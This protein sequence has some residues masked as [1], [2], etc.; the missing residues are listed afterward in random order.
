MNRELKQLIDKTF[1]DEKLIR[2]TMS[3]PRKKS[4]TCRKISMRPV[5]L[6]GGLAYQ[7]E[8]HFEKKVTHENM[9][10]AEAAD[11]IEGHLRLEF[12]QMNIMTTD[13]DI[14]VLANKIDKPR[15]TCS[16]ACHEMP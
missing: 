11:S 5:M 8:Y 14:Q 1:H 7:C 4:Q 6:H 16:S 3:R 9:T 2:L 15:I 13:E 12:K 10:P